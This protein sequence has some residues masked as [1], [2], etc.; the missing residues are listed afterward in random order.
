MKEE[1]G[2]ERQLVSEL[3]E[4]RRQLEE[5]KAAEAERK[6]TGVALSGSEDHY[7]DLVEHSRDLICTHDLEGIILSVNEVTVRLMGYDPKDF[8]NKRSIRDILA[9]EGRHLFDE[10]LAR[11]KRDGVASGLMVV[12]TSSGEKRIWE[13]HNTLRTEGVASPIVR[14]MA[15]DITEHVQM[16]RALRQSEERLAVTLRSI[17]DGAIATDREGRIVLVNNVAEKLTGWTQGDAAGKRLDDVFLLFDERTRERCYSPVEEVLDKGRAVSFTHHL[18]ARDGAE[19]T[20][21]DNAAPI[22]DGEGNIIGLVLAFRDITEQRK[23][24]E[25]LIKSG[26]LESL[27]VLAGRI[28]HDFNNILT[29]ILGNIS[30]G[31]MDAGSNQPL[32]EHLAEAEQACI[33]ARDLIQQLLTFARGGAPVKKAV[34]IARFL[35]DAVR[36]ALIDSE[37]RCD[38]DL[39]AGLWP[40]EI[41]EGQMGQVIYNLVR[42]A[43]EAMPEGG[44]ITVRAENV[45]FNES[46]HLLPLRPERGVKIAILDEGV[47][48]PQENLAKIFDP[49]FTTKAEASGLG[50]AACYS[51]V[52]SHGGYLSVESK[53][54]AGTAAYIHL[55]ASDK[56]VETKR[57]VEIEPRPGRGRILVMDDEEAIRKLC[58]D[59]LNHFGYEAA[60]ASD[61]A[62]AVELYRQ[63]KQAGHPFEAVILDLTVPAGMG[64]KEAINKLR[65]IDP[66]IKAIVSSGYSDDPVTADFRE[67]GFSGFVAKPYDINDLVQVLHDA[68]TREHE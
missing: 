54:G 65:E 43:Q 12:Q 28:A 14:G 33:R 8:I 51:I 58:R 20:I 31:Q 42:N 38:F 22:K 23:M 67:H 66:D 16:E 50:L 64:G 48:I 32:R 24:Q 61:G 29:A 35:E 1:D 27:G 5:L 49:Y 45:V 36:G 40:V 47:G 25:E 55:P 21:S 17:G 15:H 68:L 44:N 11:I 56:E 19:R 18:V 63:A 30:L 4:L 10:Y 39:G 2:A 7:R 59:V 37:M 41:D 57:K 60:L 3:A 53:P 9:P 52:R 6:R 13:Y 34:S 46:R 26:K 62:E